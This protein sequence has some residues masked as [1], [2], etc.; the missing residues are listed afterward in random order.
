ME[1][2]N[3]KVVGVVNS[4]YKPENLHHAVVFIKVEHEAGEPENTEPDLCEGWQWFEWDK[5]PQ[6]LFQPIELLLK[7]NYNPFK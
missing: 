6:P 2:R 7:Q 3:P 4:I 5:M 1:I